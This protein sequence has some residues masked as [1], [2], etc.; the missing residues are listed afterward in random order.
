MDEETAKLI[1][2]AEAMKAAR[3]EIYGD[4]C[5]DAV[6]LADLLSS[7]LTVDE[8]H[9]QVGEKHRS[10][11]LIEAHGD[12]GAAMYRGEIPTKSEYVR[13]CLE[14]V[15]NGFKIVRKSSNL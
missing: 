3:D 5:A 2:D 13:Y 7:D 14:A 9:T 15:A 12:M 8:L 6:L 4:L 1:R 10:G 11:N